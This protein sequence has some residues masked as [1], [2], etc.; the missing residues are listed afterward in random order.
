MLSTPSQ[1]TYDDTQGIFSPRGTLTRRDKRFPLSS[2]EILRASTRHGN[3]SCP[4]HRVASTGDESRRTLPIAAY[5][6]PF[7]P[8]PIRTT[9]R[10]I[11]GQFRAWHAPVSTY[12]VA[13]VARCSYATSAPVQPARPRRG[14]RR[15]ASTCVPLVLSPTR[16][17]PPYRPMMGF[18]MGCACFKAAILSHLFQGWWLN[19]Y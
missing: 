4:I 16:D 14:N 2:A 17:C 5:L 7:L 8:P 19:D 13:V 1:L 15:D 11:G 6:P 12:G 9:V 10:Q 3:E 18:I